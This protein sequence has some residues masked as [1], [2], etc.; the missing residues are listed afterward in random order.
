[1]LETL[2]FLLIVFPILGGL[3]CYIV[4]TR[5]LRGAVI[6]GTCALTAAAAVALLM[7]GSSQTTPESLFLIPVRG[8]ITLLDFALLGV[9]LWY[10]FR[11]KNGLLKVI[12][13]FQIVALA[14]YE[15][16][17]AHHTN[18]QTFYVD[19]LSIIMVLVVSIVGSL[20]CLYAIPYMKAHEE[21]LHLEKS[22]QPRFFLF[23]VGFLG[24]MNGLVLADDISFVYFFFEITTFCS[25]MLIG[26]DQTDE[27]KK[28]ATRA[29]VLNGVG[30]V[31]FVLGMIGIYA[32]AQT[33]SI[34]ELLH[35]GSIAPGLLFAVSLICLAG[36]TKAAQLP[37]Q[38]WL[39]GAMVAPTPVSALLHSST[40]VKAGVFLV[41]RF[42]PIYAGTFLGTAVAVC[43]SFTFVA[44]AALAVGQSNAK[45][46]LAYSTI[47]NLGLMIACAGLGT[48]QA[49]TAGVLLLVFHAVSKG[50][51]FC[52]V[53]HIEQHIGSRDIEAMRGLSATM[54]RA[55]LI[56]IAGLITMMLPPFGVLLSKWMAIEAAGHNLFVII[57]LAVGSALTV[58]IY[59]R[60]GGNLMSAPYKA[61]PKHPAM[62]VLTAIPLLSM[63][64]GALVLS[65]AAPL[66][67]TRLVMPLLASAPYQVAE[68]T[69]TSPVG[70]F[71]IY[72]LFLL[73]AVAFFFAMRAVLRS[74]ET[75]YIPPYFAGINL[76][77]SS[78]FTGPLGA[79]VAYESSNYYLTAIFGE[80]KLTLW[81]NMGAAMLLAMMI[82]GAL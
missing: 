59:A 53:G 80:D 34:Q 70:A 10:A 47:S 40:M 11:L 49:I 25:F 50:L 27:A 82:G 13:G 5:L 4:P 81:I 48:A 7:H 67:Y 20:I 8:L 63:A 39:L 45:K 42:A 2:L 30:G 19:T 35:S 69:L 14:F 44:A 1:M 61:E 22:R 58:L 36:F 26:H 9:I 54:P 65:L 55:A 43:G 6:V 15:L 38:S 56:T 73:L 57:M 52:C 68:G 28:N 33:M 24:A 78:G 79:P 17:Q 16:F 31:A 12:F 37:F 41:L 77:D 21:H 3:A 71:A 75:R 23:L 32:S 62:P 46:I 18:A 72:P 51:L 64:I 76:P 60:W 29:L 66:L 74:K